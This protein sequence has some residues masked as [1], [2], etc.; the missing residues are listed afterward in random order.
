[1]YSAYGLKCGVSLVITSDARRVS[2]VSGV[3]KTASTRTHLAGA[4]RWQAPTVHAECCHCA[5]SGHWRQSAFSLWRVPFTT[6]AC[7]LRLCEQKGAWVSP[8]ANVLLMLRYNH[9]S[10]KHSKND[11]KSDVKYVKKNPCDVGS[12]K[13]THFA[14]LAQTF[15]QPTHKKTS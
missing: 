11:A 8:H 9:T 4:T 15:T 10:T 1:M 13:Q 3:S 2:A 5:L 7:S 12:A 6:M 14:V